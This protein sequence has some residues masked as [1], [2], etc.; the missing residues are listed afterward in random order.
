MVLVELELVRVNFLKKA[1][2]RLK[3]I[4]AV[5]ES[6]EVRLS[7]VLVENSLDWDEFSCCDDHLNFR[8]T[9]QSLDRLELMLFDFVLLKQGFQ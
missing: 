4:V 9:C 3:D 1:D 2:V 7:I 8:L 5:M 6:L